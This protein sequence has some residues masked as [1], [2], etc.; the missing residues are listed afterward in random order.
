MCFSSFI[1]LLSSPFIMI[2]RKETQK[3]LKKQKV[4][5]EKKKALDLWELT[6]EN[7]PW[8]SMVQNYVRPTDLENRLIGL[9]LKIWKQRQFSEWEIFLKREGN[10]WHISKLFYQ[11]SK[12]VLMQKRLLVFLVEV[13]FLP[14]ID[15]LKYSWS[16]SIGC[17]LSSLSPSTRDTA[18]PIP[19]LGG[20]LIY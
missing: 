20:Y 15:S 8:K 10:Y 2:I 18:L 13:L 16:K 9:F 12:H 7:R 3:K 14:P 4:K 5:N 19:V 11:C 17:M 1:N 6:C